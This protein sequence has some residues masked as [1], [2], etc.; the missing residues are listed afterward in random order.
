MKVYIVMYSYP[1][2]SDEVCY[3]FAKEW[4]AKAYINSITKVERDYYYI[5]ERELIE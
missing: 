2:E 3:V 5:E 4:K 1:Y